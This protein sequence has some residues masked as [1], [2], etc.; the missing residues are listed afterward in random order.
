MDAAVFESR[1]FQTIA[2]QSEVMRR[3]AAFLA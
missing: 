1:N 3:M 2:M